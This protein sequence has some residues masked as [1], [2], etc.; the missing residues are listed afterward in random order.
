MPR[1]S[2]EEVVYGGEGEIMLTLANSN[3]AP[4]IVDK[5]VKP[6]CGNRVPKNSGTHWLVF[7]K[8]TEVEE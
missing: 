8:P 7:F 6:I 1:L 3:T 2:M 4:Q 5:S